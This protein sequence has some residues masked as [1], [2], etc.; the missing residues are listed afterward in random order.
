LNRQKTFS[1]KSVDQTAK[2]GKSRIGIRRKTQRNKMKTNDIKA[3]IQVFLLFDCKI[4]EIKINIE[5]LP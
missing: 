2:L 5:S 3:E 1:L 4:F